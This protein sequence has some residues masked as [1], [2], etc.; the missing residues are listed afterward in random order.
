MHTNPAGQRWHP[1]F[2]QVAPGEPLSVTIQSDIYTAEPHT[3]TLAEGETRS[4]EIVVQQIE[5]SD[6]Q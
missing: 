4:I 1:T 5:R 6:K 2:L 3:V